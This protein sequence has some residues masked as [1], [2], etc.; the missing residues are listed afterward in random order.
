MRKLFFASFLCM[1][2]LC[3]ETPPNPAKQ[4]VG[5]A[6][7]EL[8]QSGMR[9]GL[10]TGST[11]FYFIE[12]LGQRCREE[13]LSIEVAA[14]SKQSH[15]QALKEGLSL[16]DMNTL[17]SLDLTIDGADEVDSE[18]RLIKGGGGAL[19]REKILASISREFVIIVDSSKCVQA[20]GKFK[21]PV[22]VIPFAHEATLCRIQEAGYTAAWRLKKDGTLYVTD[23]GNFIVDVQLNQPTNQPEHDHEILL[24]IPGVVDTGFFFNLA[25]HILI[26]HPDGR[27]TAF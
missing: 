22:E 18:K 7:A 23:N 19:L 13:G 4:A 10:G 14:S 20:L 2:S 17:T 9:V 25:K 15:E 3:A 8:V 16:L 6:A 24:H 5:Y 11:V 1:F 21:L 27:I 26:G 12:R